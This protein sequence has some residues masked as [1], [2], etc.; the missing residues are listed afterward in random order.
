MDLVSRQRDGR[1]AL[2]TLD[3]PE[4]H[5]AL[6]QEL[7]WPLVAA[8]EAEDEDP[9]V[10]VIVVT[11]KGDSFCAGGDLREF[12]ASLEKSATTLLEEG[13]GTARLFQVMH[14]MTTPVIA[15]VNGPALGG[16]MG[17]VCASSIAVAA[18]TA[19]FG[20][21]EI[22]LGLFPLVI[23]PAMRRALGDRKALELAL[24]GAVF[25]AEEAA[26]MGL[27]TK[28]VDA[29]DVLSEAMSIAHGIGSRSPLAVE[30]GMTGFRNSLGMGTHEAI[31]YFNALRTSFLHS[32]DLREGTSAFLAKRQPKW[33][34]R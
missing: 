24:T 4:A 29:D 34:G 14:T 15:A 30:L 3:N 11:G 1:V 7:V 31:E 25:T 5:N 28:V 12:N 18:G 17:I 27:V 33:V 9:D 8:L 32:E 16:G 19:K 13:K 21:T 26:T 20:T 2:V 10:S 22:R 23:V 6:S